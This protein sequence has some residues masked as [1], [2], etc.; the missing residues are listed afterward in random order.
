MQIE[1]PS[2]FQVALLFALASLLVLASLVPFQQYLQ[3]WAQ[4][5]NE[6]CP[7]SLEMSHITTL[8]LLLG[9]ILLFSLGVLLSVLAIACKAN[10]QLSTL[11]AQNLSESFRHQM[12][13]ML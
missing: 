10:R 2:V 8:T 5:Q 9:L 13:R 6:L 11:S 12:K 4:S 7:L 1:Y 3:Y